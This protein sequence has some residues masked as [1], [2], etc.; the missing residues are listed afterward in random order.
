[1]LAPLLGL[2]MLSLGSAHADQRLLLYTM[3]AG[4][5]LMSHYGHVVLCVRDSAALRGQCYD[6]GHTDYSS[7][8]KVIWE[9][10]RKKGMYWAEVEDEAKMVKRYRRRDQS[11]WVQELRLPP[12]QRAALVRHLQDALTDAHKFYVYHHFYDNCATR[13][14][15]PIDA[16]TGG[17]LSAGNQTPDGPTY[18]EIAET[19]LAG[20]L[21][22]Q[23]ALELGLGREAD[24]VT[25]PWQRMLLPSE[26]REQVAAHLGA[27][28]EQVYARVGPPMPK[29]ANHGRVAVALLGL[30]LGAANLLQRRFPRATLRAT[31]GIL[32]LPALAFW[33]VALITA[34]TELRWNEALLVQWPTDLALP[35][36]GEGTRRRYLQARLVVLALVTALWGVGMLIQPLGPVLLFVGLPVAALLVA[37]RA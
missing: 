12:D 2:W 8:V 10:M 24:T 30:A 28:P 15:D 4:D 23:I 22:L 16:V 29:T 11:I 34:L 1:M 32:G 35:W 9:F 17:L 36:M 5:D 20:F 27:E 21:P 26:L 37:R 18:R 3:G 19:G 14:R 13:L 33:G 25:S 6:F 31:A 7:T